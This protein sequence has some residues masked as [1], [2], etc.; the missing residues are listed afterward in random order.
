VQPHHVDAVLPLVLNH[1]VRAGGRSAPP[2]PSPSQ[3]EQQPSPQSNR[4]AQEALERIFA[5]SRVEAPAIQVAFADQAA[6]GSSQ[7]MTTDHPGPVLRSRRTENPA[8]IDIRAT[9]SHA[10]LETG[11]VH[12]RV[13]DLHEKVREPRTGTRYLFVIDSSGSHAAQEKM[14]LVKGAVLSLLSRSF[15]KDDEV[16]IIAFRGT[17]AQ[18]LLEPCRMMQDAAAAL[19]YLP[20]GGRTPLAHALELAK[21]YLTPTTLLVLLSDGRANVA[22]QGGDPW[23]DALRAAEQLHGHAL[24]VDTED[25]KQPLGRA[26]ELAR[27][28]NASWIALDSVES[29]S[30]LKITSQPAHTER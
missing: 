29:T 24:V 5:P 14:R 11:D 21:S 26:K 13:S 7:A 3:Q 23:Q 30:E 17:A 10:V 16:A 1:R 18:V 15:K 2:P 20:T 6:R 22:L 25:A 8:E 19:E 12:P 9:V 27:A 4:N 28:L